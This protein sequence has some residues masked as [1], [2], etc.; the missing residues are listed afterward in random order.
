MQTHARPAGLLRTHALLI[1]AVTSLTMLAALGVSLTRPASYESVARVVVHAEQVDGGTPLPP[2]MGTEREIALSG[3]VAQEAGEELG[4]TPGTAQE[5]LQ[6]DVP[7]DT[8]VLEFSYAADT[9]EEAF[10]G[11]QVFTEAYVD[12]RNSLDTAVA[13]IITSPSIPSAP[14]RPNVYL[15]LA[16]SLLMGLGLGVAIA[17]AWDRL[18]PRLRDLTDVEAQTGLPVLAAI[19]TLRAAPGERIVVGSSQA[20]AGAEAYGHLTARLLSLLQSNDARSV[21]ITSPTAGAGKT[22]V[23]LNLAASL[24][25]AGKDTVVVSAD[26]CDAAMHIRSRF[27]RRPG[28]RELLRDEATLADALHETE[29]EGLRILPPGGAVQAP[30]PALNVGRLTGVLEELSRLTDV[31]LIDAPSVLGSAD[32]AILAEQ[33]DLTLLVVDIRRGRRAAAAAAV[34]TL[35]HVESR[36]PGCVVNDPGRKRQATETPQQSRRNRP[37][38]RGSIR[39]EEQEDTPSTIPQPNRK[40]RWQSRASI[41]K[42]NQNDTPSTINSKNAEAVTRLRAGAGAVG[43]DVPTGTSGGTDSRVADVQ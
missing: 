39:T 26:A 34:R 20:A 43:P 1:V 18:A 21:V 4:L 24:A 28:L 7:V 11:A 41:R 30:Q 16:L 9:G 15:V 3:D 42:G 25:A 19:P 8:N 37:R 38:S 17:Y 12:Y 35:S 13:Q 10:R 33:A 22:T 36:L 6:V 27:V 32:T 40:G 5:H 23:T 29:I 31:V 2:D 14:T